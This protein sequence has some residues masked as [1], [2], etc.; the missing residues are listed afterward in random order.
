DTAYFKEMVA[1]TDK[2]VGSIVDKLSEHRLLDNTLIL[3]TGDNGT[4]R[5]IVSHT[6][7]GPIAGGKGKTIDAGT[8][9]PLIAHWPGAGQRGIVHAGLI[10]FSDFYPTLVDVVGADAP[11]DG[12]SFYPLLTGGDYE[13]R[14][15]AFVHYDP[16]WGNFVNQFRN[17][18]ARTVRYKL[19]RDSTFYDIKNDPLEVSP[20]D[21]SR[22][23]GASLSD[24]EALKAELSRHPEFNYDQK[25]VLGD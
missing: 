22:L 17:Q 10:E 4:D 2:I 24:Y 8:R 6:V 23:S 15:T 12:R 19:Y 18:F 7:N 13:P 25:P 14:Q 5:P 20:L 16:Q 9:V 1:Y 21:I 11:S 3:F